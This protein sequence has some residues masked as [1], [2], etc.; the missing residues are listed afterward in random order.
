MMNDVDQPFFQAR[1]RA[2]E[3]ASEGARA[4]ARTRARAR[5]WARTRARVS[6]RAQRQFR[7][8]ER[9]PARRARDGS[10]S[11]AAALVVPLDCESLAAGR[12]RD[13]GRDSRSRLSLLPRAPPRPPSHLSVCGA[14]PSGKR[15]HD[16]FGANLGRDLGDQRGILGARPEPHARREPPDRDYARGLA[17]PQGVRHGR[18]CER[19]CSQHGRCEW[20]CLHLDGRCESSCLPHWRCEWT[21][22]VA[23]ITVRPERSQPSP[24]ATQSSHHHHHL[25]TTAAPSLV[26]LPLLLELFIVQFLNSYASLYYTAFVM[27]VRQTHY[28]R[29]RHPS[30]SIRHRA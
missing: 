29:R 27:K 20:S 10:S 2:S 12:R 28:S 11:S 7:V 15:R 18:C 23:T 26:S 16:L 4:R 3:R 14:P 8:E 22:L 5:A 9:R 21:D 13:E 6:V 17:H 25:H 24:P 19:S 30:T 1:E